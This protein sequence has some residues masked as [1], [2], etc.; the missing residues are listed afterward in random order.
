MWSRRVEAGEPIYQMGDRPEGVWQVV[1]GMVG[2]RLYGEDGRTRLLRIVPRSGI[3]GYRAYLSGEEHFTS[4]YSISGGT[5][6][7]VPGWALRRVAEEDS[8]VLMALQR[9]L[10]KALR[11]ANQRLLDQ[12]T[13]NLAERFIRFLA[14]IAAEQEGRRADEWQRVPLPIS[15]QDIASLLGVSPETLSRCIR[16]LETGG[17]VRGHRRGSI[18]LAPQ[19]EDDA[20]EVSLRCNR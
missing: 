9:H 12:A 1:E 16:K 15:Y 10:A 19:A 4:A 6:R 17:L 2:L 8:E 13:T 3:F 18:E 11:Q 20:A 14:D 7:H 5:V